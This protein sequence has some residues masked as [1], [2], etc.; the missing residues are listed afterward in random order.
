MFHLWR[1]SVYIY[2]NQVPVHTIGNSQSGTESRA[3]YNE[4]PE[5]V[6]YVHCSDTSQICKAKQGIFSWLAT[7]NTCHLFLG[8]YAISITPEKWSPR[9][10]SEWNLSKSKLM[11]VIY[12]AILYRGS[13]V[14][15]QSRP[16]PLFPLSSS[17]HWLIASICIH[18][19]NRVTFASHRPLLKF[20]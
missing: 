6:V 3:K 4:S 11:C 16:Y 10:Q 18:P 12:V 13:A 8:C 14:P 19:V 9:S 20:Q 1:Y 7:L 15:R 17:C 5:R 2:A